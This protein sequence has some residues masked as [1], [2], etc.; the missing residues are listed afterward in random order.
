MLSVVIKV[1]TDVKRK[2]TTISSNIEAIL[3]VYMTIC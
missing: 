1:L 3:L 2:K